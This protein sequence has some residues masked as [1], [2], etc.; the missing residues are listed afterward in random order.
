MQFAKVPATLGPGLGC[1]LVTLFGNHALSI[2]SATNTSAAPSKKR[3]LLPLLSVLF[4]IAYTLMTMLIVEQGQTI[5]SQR[6]LIRELF[7]DSTELSAAKMKPQQELQN[8]PSANAQA[9]VAE[10]PSSQ[11]HATKNPSTQAPTRQ[12]PSSQAGPQQRAE[13]SAAT[14][15]PQFRMPSKPEADLIDDVRTLI[16]I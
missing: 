16:T 10:I 12:A 3:T 2:G 14:K 13:H 7:R 9:P 5:E 4:V 11:N 15:K 6:S 1:R 8:R